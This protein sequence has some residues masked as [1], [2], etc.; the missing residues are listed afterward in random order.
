MMI[1]KELYEE[2]V[3]ST[4]YPPPESGG[5]LGGHNGVVTIFVSDKGSDIKTSYKYKPDTVFFN[6]TINEWLNKNIDF[7]G[8]YHSHPHNCEALSSA[9][10]EY[11]NEI[12]KS[13][14]GYTDKLYFPIVIPKEKIISYYALIVADE[15]Q[16][17][18]D[19]I[20]LL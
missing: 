9:D 13:I 14:S 11:I 5:L 8:I 17:F 2:I 7:M 18:H 19:A 10:I 4:L 3:F 15:I 12:M 6:R 16:I 20:Q 1:S